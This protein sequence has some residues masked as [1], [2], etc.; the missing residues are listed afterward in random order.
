M[1]TISALIP[2]LL[3]ASACGSA[4]HSRPMASDA[5]TDIRSGGLD[6]VGDGGVGDRDAS[7]ADRGPS[8]TPKATDSI[9]IRGNLD[10]TTPSH[11]WNI[12]FAAATSSFAT[13]LVVY[14]SLGK[15]IQVDIYFGKDDA[16]K[17][18]GDSGAWRYHVTTDGVNLRFQ[19][20]GATPAIPGAPTQIAAGLLRF[21]TSGRLVSSLTVNQGFYPKNAQI[22]QML[23]L[24]F[25]TGIESGGT[26][27]DGI[28]QYA[29]ASAFSLVTQSGWP[30]QP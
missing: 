10:A 18:P 17:A 29:G 6:G 9:T 27:L 23:T 8:K 7:S 25:G 2:L 5:G 13:S 12:T 15:A 3:L 21:D 24:N 4:S 1:R 30:Y 14:D 16:A 22:P 11:V 20:D 19:A 28:T 26:G